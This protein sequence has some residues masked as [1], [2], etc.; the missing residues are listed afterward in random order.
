MKLW[1]CCKYRKIL[2][3]FHTLIPLPLPLH[4]SGE[5]WIPPILNWMWCG[6]HLMWN[7]SDLEY[8]WVWCGIHPTVLLLLLQ[9]VCC[10]FEGYQGYDGIWSRGWKWEAIWEAYLQIGPHAHISYKSKQR[11]RVLLHALPKSWHC[12]EGG[13]KLIHSIQSTQIVSQKLFTQNC[14]LTAKLDEAAKQSRGEV[15]QPWPPSTSFPFLFFH[16]QFYR[17]CQNFWSNC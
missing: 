4:P 14:Y 11:D 9:G 13:A 7:T 10:S 8:I 1:V 6:I 5:N 15:S 12:Q 17:Q 3:S 2:R 16:A